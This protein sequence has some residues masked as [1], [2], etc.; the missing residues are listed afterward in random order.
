MSEPA[1][2]PGAPQTLFDVMVEGKRWGGSYDNISA[3]TI[4]CC[5]AQLAQHATGSGV[6]LP[7]VTV[8]DDTTGDTIA[9]I[10]QF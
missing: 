3:V 1:Q 6:R 7:L 10:G 5:V 4:A 2:T 9:A 8:V